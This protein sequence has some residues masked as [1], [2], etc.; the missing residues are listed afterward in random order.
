VERALRC[1][2]PDKASTSIMS[3]HNKHTRSTF[4]SRVKTR[5]LFGYRDFVYSI[6]T[7]CHHYLT[8][9]VSFDPIMKSIGPGLIEP[10]FKPVH[11]AE[12]KIGNRHDTRDHRH[13][14][15]DKA[16]KG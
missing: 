4:D 2:S 7:I 11:Q 13:E 9:S 14:R 10:P 3:F 12:D 16:K 5:Q 1:Q 15:H 6:E 8:F